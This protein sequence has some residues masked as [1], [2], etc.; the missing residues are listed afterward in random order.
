MRGAVGGA[1]I[2]IPADARQG[3]TAPRA[4]RKGTR[5]CRAGRLGLWG[6]GPPPP[7]PPAGPCRT[8]SMLTVTPAWGSL[9]AVC[10]MNA[11]GWRRDCHPGGSRIGGAAPYQPPRR[12][13]NGRR[14]WERPPD[15]TA[16]AGRQVHGA[17]GAAGRCLRV[18]CRRG[19]S[20]P[21]LIRKGRAHVT[22]VCLNKGHGKSG[23]YYG[24]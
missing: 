2:I 18:G 20:P 7:T 6:A 24:R 12:R 14:A 15:R 13:Q 23:A 3:A 16:T 10:E 9:L 17:M 19:M 22:H 21:A 8:G 1:G 11:G 4:P 5:H